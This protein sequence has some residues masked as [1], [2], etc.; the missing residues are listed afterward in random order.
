MKSGKNQSNSSKV[1][2][3]VLTVFLLISI[4]PATALADSDTRY[5]SLDENCTFEVNA[6]VSSAWSGHANI[7]LKVNNIGDKKIDNWHLTF[8]TPYI[9]ENIW[10]ASIVESDDKGTYTIRNNIY[11]QDIEVGSEA[12]IGMT[13]NLG[14]KEYIELSDWYLLNIQTKEVE[15]EKYLVSYQ[16]YSKWD[17]GFNGALILSSQEYIE[18][19][20]LCF[21]SEYEITAVSNAIIETQ[22]NNTYVISNDGYSQNLSANM[23]FVSVQG[24]PTE[25]E[26]AIDNVSMK[27]IGLGYTLTEDSD[28]NG[29]ADYLDYIY[30]QEGTESVTPTPTDIPTITPIPT[31]TDEPTEAPTVTPEPT[32]TVS[33]DYD[34]FSDSDNDGLLD[35]EEELYGT[36]KNNP[37]SDDDGIN[38]FTEIGI[39]YYPNDRDSDKN[40]TVDG[41]EDFDKDGLTNSVEAGY[42]TCL[43]L[44]DSDFDDINDYDEIIV[45]GTDPNKE[46]SN[47]DGILDGDALKL[48][49]NPASLDSDGDGILDKDEKTYQEMGFQIAEDADLKGVTLVEIKGNFTNLISSTTSIE[50]V[51]GKDVYS[52]QIEAIVGGLV[53]IETSS[54]FDTATIVFHYD[55]NEIG[56]DE[57]DLCILWY[58][59]ANGD[60]VMLDEEQILD[61]ENNTVSY[62]TTHFSEYMLISKTKWIATWIKSIKLLSENRQRYLNGNDGTVKYLIAMNYADIDTEEFRG[63]SYD[64]FDVVMDFMGEQDII[65]LTYYNAYSY[66]YREGSKSEYIE[67]AEDLTYKTDLYGDKEGAGWGP[68]HTN[69]LNIVSET[70]RIFAKPDEKV[71]LI[72]ITDAYL[73]NLDEAKEEYEEILGYEPSCDGVIVISLNDTC[74]FNSESYPSV[75]IDKE[76]SSNK[77]TLQE[78]FPQALS[79]VL[80]GLHFTKD[81]TKDTDGDNLS[82]Y[83]ETTGHLLSN[84]TLIFTDPDTKYT[85]NDSLTDYT[86]LGT[87]KNVGKSSVFKNT[88]IESV[89]GINIDDIWYWDYKSDPTVEDT[90]SDDFWDDEDARPK[91]SNPEAVYLF[92]SP[93]FYK[94]AE[95]MYSIYLSHGLTT[96]FKEFRGIDSFVQEWNGIGMHGAYTGYYYKPKNVVLYCHGNNFAILLSKKIEGEQNEILCM[97]EYLN[98]ESELPIRVSELEDKRIESLNLYACYCGYKEE[99]LATN[100]IDKKNGIKKVV[101]ADAALHT[102]IS[103]PESMEFWFMAGNINIISEEDKDILVWLYDKVTDKTND[104]KYNLEESTG[105]FSPGEYTYIGGGLTIEDIANAC[106]FK[107]FTKNLSPYDLYSGINEDVLRGEIYITLD[108]YN[109]KDRTDV[110]I[111]YLPQN[112]PYSTVSLIHDPVLDM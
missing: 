47:D 107:C 86:E 105:C 30:S 3:L 95:I 81:L 13:L 78:R 10:N 11:N 70:K 98:K 66:S 2:C 72:M 109:S 52:S 7:E 65:L 103:G 14:D 85:D 15:S 34:A 26:F 54:D 68:D 58:D 64:A 90:D 87:K 6:V 62:V 99:N 83:E 40:G 42:G 63:Q 104:G 71:V 36:D 8:K 19:W 94:Y 93:D 28:E 1:L 88:N 56:V 20:S 29:I 27:S 110:P 48:G 23:L 60:Y 38:D 44:P 33:P 18:D 37:D 17:N 9:I 102:A 45:Y 111:V 43:F 61:K 108:G 106:G 50:D 91:I 51:Y 73:I 22:D 74:Y 41:D 16:E 21:D 92:A 84:G 32:A 31:I 69:L 57:E 100:F 79:E 24:I 55:E 67:I 25:N 5:Y 49:L 46:D 76:I 35:Y 82:N 39:G 96:F 101:A 77:E 112:L 80:S 4:I 97:D 59:E 75:K 12:T 53:S 89:L